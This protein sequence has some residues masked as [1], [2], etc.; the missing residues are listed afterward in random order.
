MTYMTELLERAGTPAPKAIGIDEILIGKGVVSDSINR[1]RIW[2]GGNDRSEDRMR[3]FYNW[4]GEKNAE[5]IRLAVM[6]MRKFLRNITKERVF[7]TAILFDKRVCPEFCAVRE[8]T[9]LACTC[10]SCTKPSVI[11]RPPIRV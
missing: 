4:L 3:Q 5:D 1:R 2:F 8:C 11:F 9:D 10:Q 7:Q 6:D